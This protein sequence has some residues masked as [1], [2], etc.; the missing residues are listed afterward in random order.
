MKGNAPQEK[1]LFENK[2]IINS[3]NYLIK[4]IEIINQIEK[5]INHIIDSFI[6]SKV[7]LF[8]PGK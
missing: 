2:S 5:S 3:I 1:T 7:F 4:E 6:L 8:R